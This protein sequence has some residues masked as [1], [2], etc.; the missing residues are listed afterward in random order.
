M[1]YLIVSIPDLCTLTYFPYVLSLNLVNWF[2]RGVLHVCS[3]RLIDEALKIEF[4]S[5]SRLIASSTLSEPVI[6]LSI[7]MFFFL[8]SLID[9]TYYLSWISYLPGK[10]SSWHVPV[11]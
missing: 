7:I 11:L 3:L 9:E 5:L 1:W 8:N 2:T 10:L 4:D 6:K